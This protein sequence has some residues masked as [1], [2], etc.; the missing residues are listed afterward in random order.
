MVRMSSPSI[1]SYLLCVRKIHEKFG[2]P[3]AAR[4]LAPLGSPWALTWMRVTTG[5]V[6]FRRTFVRGEELS[7]I[8]K[9]RARTSG[10]LSA[11]MVSRVEFIAAWRRMTTFRAG[12]FPPRFQWCPRTP[13]SVSGY[14]AYQLVFGSNPVDL[15]G[16]DDKDG[17]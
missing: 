17:D 2:M 13:I 5:G 14:P 12:R 3:P 16:W 7:C 9:G 1:P 8:L 4:G 10:F 11:D 15:F 6:K